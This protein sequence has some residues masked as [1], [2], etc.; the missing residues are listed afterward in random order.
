MLGDTG[1][2]GKNTKDRF[3]EI[4][5]DSKSCVQGGY[6]AVGSGPPPQSDRVQGNSGAEA[7]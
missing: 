7:K 4:G 5:K 6:N 2:A 1:T 3:P